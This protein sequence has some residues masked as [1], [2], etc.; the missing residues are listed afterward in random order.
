MEQQWLRVGGVWRQQRIGRHDQGVSPSTEVVSGSDVASGRFF[1][2]AE[3]EARSRVCILGAGL[4]EVLSF[5]SADIG[6]AVT[7]DGHRF[8][9][10]GIGEESGSM[11]GMGLDN[12]ITVPFKTFQSLFS[13]PDGDVRITVLPRTEVTMEA[14]GEEAASILRRVRGLSADD[15]DNFYIITQESALSSIDELLSTVAAVTIGIAAISLL[16]GGIGIMNITLVSVTERT[17]EIGTRRAIGAR[18]SDIVLQFLAEA[19][20]VSVNGGIAGLLLG[21]AVI[22]AVNRLTP[23]PAVVS[24][25]SVAVAMGFSVLVGLLFGVFPAWKAAELVPIEALR[26]E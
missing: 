26:Y 6:S 20:I 7:V 16:V 18:K 19:V 10:T 21:V 5:T 22:T 2:W 23:L 12:E 11:F 4:A 17:R 3:D 15:E 1:T 13:R 8:T 24:G 9:V 25:W 14:C